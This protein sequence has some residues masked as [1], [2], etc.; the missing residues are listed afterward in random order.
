MY[1]FKTSQ[2]FISVIYL[3]TLHYQL[4]PTIYESIQ[5]EKVEVGDVI[6]IEANTGSVKVNFL[7]TFSNVYIFKQVSLQ[8]CII[9]PTAGSQ[10]SLVTDDCCDK[11]PLV[12]HFES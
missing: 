4:D 2:L 12:G 5:K 8:A 10:G 9:L 7:L 3:T 11:Q 1:P 6:Y